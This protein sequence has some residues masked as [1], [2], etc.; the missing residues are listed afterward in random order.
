MMKTLTGIKHNRK[1]GFTLIE[2]LVALTIAAIAVTVA[3]PTLNSIFGENLKSSSRKLSGVIKYIYNQAIIQNKTMRLV[4]D[5]NENKYWAEI[6]T[7]EFMLV[8]E[9]DS[10]FD[11]EEE[12]E[13]KDEFVEVTNRLIKPRKLDGDVRF[14]SVFT[15][16]KGILVEEGKAYTHFFPGGF[17]ENTIIH[18]ALGE[19]VFSLVIEP[20]LG[21]AKIYDEY[22]E[23]E[24]E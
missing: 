15:S 20:M 2:L 17:V 11:M 1:T 22:V 4:Y 8:E 9:D 10:I 12:E 3:I 7:G 23:P 18:L 5:F 19:K 14:L 21:M 24:F 16:I 6:A 13:K